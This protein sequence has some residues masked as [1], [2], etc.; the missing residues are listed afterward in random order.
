M[1][2][3]HHPLRPIQPLS[4]ITIKHRRE[5]QIRRRDFNRRGRLRLEPQRTVPRHVLDREQGA[6]G[7][8][9][10]VEIAIADE[11]AVGRFDDLWQDGLD[12][13]GGEITFGFGAAGV[14]VSRAGFGTADEDGIDGAFGPGY[15][16]WGVQGGFHVGA[17][18]VG[19]CAFG[20]VDELGGEGEDVPEE[21]ALLIDLV[22]VEAGVDGQKGVV[23]HGEDV[24]GGV[25]EEFGGLVARWGE[26]EVGVAEGGVAA[27]LVEGGDLG[28]ECRVEVEDVLVCFDEGVGD[29]FFLGVGEVADDGVVDQCP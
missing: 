15:A 1:L 10:H 13:V 27:G 26:G 12:G 17:V 16:G 22:D 23:E 5:L 6:V 4:A 11:H 24:A 21:G 19:V 8:D 14:V 9:D 7:D 3:T 20:G 25:V 28:E 29:D 18:E 2:H